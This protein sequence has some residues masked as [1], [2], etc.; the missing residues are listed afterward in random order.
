MKR[1]P[2]VMMGFSLEQE[3][4]CRRDGV[5]VIKEVGK[6]LNL[7]AS[8]T[9]ATAC[10]FFH[11]FYMFHSFK[12]HPKN[13]MALA[14]LFLAGKVEETPKK[15]RDI[16][17]IGQKHFYDQFT[18]DETPEDLMLAERILLQT[19][20]FDLHVEHPYTFL[21]QYAK[22]FRFDKDYMSK[23]VTD[24]WTFLNDSLGTTL[25]LLWEPE[26]LA[27]SMLY[28]SFKLERAVEKPF[29]IDSNIEWWNIYVQNL[30]VS[31][32]DDICHKVLD[33]IG[34][35]EENHIDEAIALEMG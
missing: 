11:R 21:I 16:L 19:L 17:T 15:C 34:P 5:K 27:I 13:M 14:C 28:M 32:M 3:D 12:D 29:Q 35:P 30:S 4:G 7:K 23:I 26:V 6:A 33:A 24:A 9:L 20:R 8:P 25:C 18:L 31:L 22:G 2:S 10:V 1:T